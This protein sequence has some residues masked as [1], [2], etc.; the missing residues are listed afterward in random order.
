MSDLECVEHLLHAGRSR[1]AVVTVEPVSNVLF[2]RQV[3]KEREILSD[4][5]RVPPM[6]GHIDAL[7]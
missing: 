3:R 6:H 7:G 5:P 4:V 2:D 1:R